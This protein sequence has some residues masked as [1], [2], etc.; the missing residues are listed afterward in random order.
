METQVKYSKIRKRERRRMERKRMEGTKKIEKG[1][2]MGEREGG[3]RGYNVGYRGGER[4]C[5][6][7][8][9]IER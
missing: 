5:T 2:D 8:I 1:E 4:Y 9:L 3:G 6:V 7:I